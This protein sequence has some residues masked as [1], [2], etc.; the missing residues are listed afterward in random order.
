MILAV[1]SDSHDHIDNL[2]W[3][4]AES[5]AA[6]CGMILHCGDFVAPF[7][8]A[9]LDTAGIPVHGVFG[10]NDGDQYL[11][12][13]NALTRHQHITLHG[14]V[15]QLTA[16]GCRIAFLHDG[17]LAEDIAA[18]GRFDLIC[19]GHIHVY[20]E[21]KVG[22]TLVLNPGEVMGKEGPPGFC[23]VD[24]ATMTVTRV[25]RDA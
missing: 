13:W 12:T 2:R 8:L 17:S 7:M 25:I 11:M 22:D 4:V 6:G 18:G 23:L 5:R 1:M 24:T 10:N 14:Q 3:A 15:G 19:F 9:E 16:D 21:K 20:V